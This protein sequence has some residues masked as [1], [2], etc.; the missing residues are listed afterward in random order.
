MTNLPA[1][2]LWEYSFLVGSNYTSSIDWVFTDG[3]ASTWYSAGNWHAF[4]AP[5]YSP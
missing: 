5:Y 2:T 3:T 1:S 4:M